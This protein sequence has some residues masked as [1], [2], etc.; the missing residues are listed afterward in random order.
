[1]AACRPA[2]KTQGNWYQVGLQ[3][4]NGTWQLIDPPPKRKVIGTKWVYKVKY[5]SDDS[6]E[7]YKARLVAQGFSQVEGFDVHETFAPTVRIASI[8]LIL[9]LAAHNNWKGF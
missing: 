4:K 8:R 9:A 2:S 1:M 7:K 6:L 3:S 5:K